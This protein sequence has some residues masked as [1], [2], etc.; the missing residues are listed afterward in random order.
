MSA[1]KKIKDYTLYHGDCLEVMERLEDESIDLVLTDPP[2]GITANKWDSV[3]PFDDMWSRLC[4]LVKYKSALILFGCEPFSSSLRLS[5]K[6]MY[7]YDWIWKKTHGTNFL[8]SS[9]QPLKVYEN[10]LIFSKAAS[11]FSKKGSMNYKPQKT[12]GV[13]YKATRSRSRMQYHSNI[14]GYT[15]ENQGDRH[16]INIISYN[17]EKGLHPTQK[18]VALLEYLIKT[19][20]NEGDTVLDFTMGSGSTGV[21]CDNLNRKFIGIELEK[22]Y[23]DIAVDRIENNERH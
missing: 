7:K 13:P 9:N 14:E 19:Y 10:I 6:K 21:A 18:P 5:N 23:F 1:I 20:T 11:S 8:N 16:P 2:Y 3:I 12:K 4:K 15:T 17:S 22:K